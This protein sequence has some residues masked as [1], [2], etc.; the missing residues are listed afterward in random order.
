M[1]CKYCDFIARIVALNTTSHQPR[2]ADITSATGSPK[3]F[4]R[5]GWHTCL[6]DH[7]KQ[8]ISSRCA[9]LYGFRN[10]GIVGKKNEEDTMKGLY[11]GIECRDKRRPEAD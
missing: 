5:V 8:R 3:S 10:E 9:V 1:N 4:A 11:S 2:L 6:A 7:T